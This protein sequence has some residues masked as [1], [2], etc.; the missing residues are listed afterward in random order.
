MERDN[1]YT[2]AHEALLTLLDVILSMDVYHGKMWGVREQV[3]QMEPKSKTLHQYIRCI[4]SAANEIK[5]LTKAKRQSI[6][7]ESWLV[8]YLKDGKEEDN[9]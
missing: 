6:H 5:Y 1:D 3:S 2:R 7:L 8:S 9:G 4:N